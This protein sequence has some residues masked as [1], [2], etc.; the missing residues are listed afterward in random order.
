MPP[1]LGVVGALFG[2]AVALIS[3]FPADRWVAA[4]PYLACTILFGVFV[5]VVPAL[6]AV[7]L[8]NRRP[9]ALA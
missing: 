5:A 6:W 2:A 8:M 9:P 7:V 3:G 4:A 1:A